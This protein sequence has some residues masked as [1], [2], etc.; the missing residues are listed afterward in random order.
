MAGLHERIFMTIKKRR[1]TARRRGTAWFS[2]TW[3]ASRLRLYGRSLM[4]AI[5]G[6]W[7]LARLD[8]LLWRRMPLAIASA[9][10]PP[11]G[12]AVMLVVLSLTV[13]HEQVALVMQSHGPYAMKMAKIIEADDDA[14]LLSVTS[15]PEATRMLQNEEIAA[16]ITIP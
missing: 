14:Y 13:T 7:A 3:R 11:I 9:L 2:R 15:M 5:R 8:L 4:G 16:I 12:M 6:M 1:G 10:I